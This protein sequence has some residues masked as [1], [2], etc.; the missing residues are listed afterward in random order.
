MEVP[1]AP[2]DHVS[3][4]IAEWRKERPD[5]PV[6]PVAVV[7]RIAR[8]AAHLTAEVERL[9]AESRIS[10]ADFALLANLRRSGA[11]YQLSQRQLMDA[12]RL[13]SGTISVRVDRL[14][15]RDLVRREADPDDGRGVLVTLT[16]RGERFVDEVAPKHL[17]NEARLVAALSRDEQAQLAR[18]LQILLVEFEGPADPPGAQL[19]FTVAPAHIGQ[20]RRSAVGLSPTVGLL[21]DQVSHGGPAA[22]A[23]LLP[24]DLLVRSGNTALRSLTCLANAID[25]STDKITFRI[26]RADRAL[27]VA[28]ALDHPRRERAPRS[29][30]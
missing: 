17:A 19:G 22:A 14:C 6:E 4:L 10:G 21:V 20:Q 24:G 15:T 28:I 7:Y 26:H 9:F 18:L 30:R 23:G 27:T 11:P 13:T 25:T 29:L 12:L 8:L 3:R 16:D 1:R 2:D 5:L